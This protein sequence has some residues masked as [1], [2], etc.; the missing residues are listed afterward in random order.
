M[1]TLDNEAELRTRYREAGEGVRR[2]QIDHVDEGAA[3]FLEATTLAVVAT[4]GPDGA[5]ASPRGGPPGFIRRIDTGH[6]AFGD[7]SGNNRLD[8]YTNVTERADV[9]LLCIVP[10]VEE[11]LRIN[12]R[13]SVSVDP[14]V[15]A[16]VALP[17]VAGGAD[18][19]PKVA[20]V[21]EVAECYIHCGKALRR[22]GLWDP[23]SWPA[24][25][26]RPSPST[27]LRDHIDIDVDPALIEADL[28]KNYV[29]TLWEHGGE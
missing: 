10:G 12:G 19:V 9:G 1:T 25:D 2:K 26:D 11:T 13:A 23:D 3:S 6:V 16:A 7:L 24:T 4:F 20:L 22:A 15:L 5:D 8:T 18:K 27:I 29:A 21:I 28:E 14:D 17:A